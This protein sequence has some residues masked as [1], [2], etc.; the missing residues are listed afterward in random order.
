MNLDEKVEKI[1]T[2]GDVKFE[3]KGFISYGDDKRF[4]AIVGDDLYQR[5]GKRY[6]LLKRDWKND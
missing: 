2:T 3:V 4:F 6:M 1:T 5:N